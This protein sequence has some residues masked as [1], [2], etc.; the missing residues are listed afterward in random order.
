MRIV[1]KRFFRCPVCRNFLGVFLLNANKESM[2]TRDEANCA[3]SPPQKFTP[4]S[5]LN[6][7]FA[8]AGADTFA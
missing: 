8:S 2:T 6:P 4:A 1:E 5:P 7:T 3:L